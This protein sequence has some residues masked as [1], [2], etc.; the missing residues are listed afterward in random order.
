MAENNGDCSKNIPKMRRFIEATFDPAVQHAYK[1]FF[2]FVSHYFHQRNFEF[3]DNFQSPASMVLITQWD[4][5]RDIWKIFRHIRRDE[6]D[7]ME[8]ISTLAFGFHTLIRQRK[9]YQ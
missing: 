7:D 6:S 5:E 8:E 1:L 9:H 3:P 4:S 2:I